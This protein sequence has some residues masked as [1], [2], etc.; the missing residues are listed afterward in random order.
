MESADGER[1]REGTREGAGDGRG[2]SR[3]RTATG[4][5]GTGT[6]RILSGT[7]RDEGGRATGWPW[8]VGGDAQGRGS[9]WRR[10][11]RGLC[12]WMHALICATSLADARRSL[13]TDAAALC[14]L[15]LARTGGGT[16][17]RQAHHGRGGHERNG[18]AE[19]TPGRHS[20]RVPLAPV[21]VLVL[22]GGSVVNSPVP[23]SNHL[24]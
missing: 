22:N 20:K 15:S 17:A 7:H 5:A 21:C 3:Q 13:L 4:D 2:H 14:L 18:S 10:T 6:A 16:G 9:L 11:A 1:E 19:H 12:P 24:P 8:G 23:V